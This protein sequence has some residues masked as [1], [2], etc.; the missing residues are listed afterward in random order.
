ML[1]FN[2]A[3]SLLP[4]YINNPLAYLPE[5]WLNKAEDIS[6]FHQ[7]TSLPFGHGARMC[8]GRNIAMQEIVVVLK[9]VF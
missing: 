6:N 5:R 9:E 2:S 4:D 7:F 3:S 1:A 8:P